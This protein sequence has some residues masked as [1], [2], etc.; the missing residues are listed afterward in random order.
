MARVHIA[1][2]I[3]AVSLLSLSPLVVI[4]A[5]DNGFGVEY[6]NPDFHKVLH[7]WVVFGWKTSVVSVSVLA[8]L[9]FAGLSKKTGV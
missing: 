1:S 9:I 2:V 8:V 6:I 5:F 3:I 4:T 7:H